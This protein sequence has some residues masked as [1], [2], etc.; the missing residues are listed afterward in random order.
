MVKTIIGGV[1]VQE[2]I[3]AYSCNCP[4]VN[5]N[6]G[7]YDINGNYV[8]DKKGDEVLLDITLEGVPTKVSK[9]LASAV[10]GKSVEVDYTTPVPSHGTFY[11]TDYNAVCDN[12][13]PDNPDY[14]DDS[15]IEWN[16]HIS[17]RSAEIISPSGGLQLGT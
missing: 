13:D 8:S 1:A 9:Q 15:G 7:F 12:A 5:G 10:A 11:K 14:D 17:L 3:T 16:I 6:N 4:P 2:Y